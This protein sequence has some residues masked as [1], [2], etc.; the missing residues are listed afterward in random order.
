MKHIIVI[1]TVDGKP[2]PEKLQ[3]V[4]IRAVDI[5]VSGGHGICWVQGKFNVDSAIAA[6]HEMFN[7][8]AWESEQSS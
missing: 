8:P 5:G 7:A 3:A 1:E 6:V 2:L 4:L